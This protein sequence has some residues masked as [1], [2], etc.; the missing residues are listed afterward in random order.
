MPVLKSEE[1]SK[2]QNWGPSVMN[3][4]ETSWQDWSEGEEE[5]EE[6]L[7]PDAGEGPSSLESIQL[8][9]GERDQVVCWEEAPPQCHWMAHLIRPPLCLQLVL[10]YSREAGV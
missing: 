4:M 1:D 7:E 8:H 2:P 5:W 3:S 9:G 6:G 10:P